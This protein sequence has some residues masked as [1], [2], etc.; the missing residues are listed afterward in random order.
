MQPVSNT[1]PRCGG[2]ISA[3]VSGGQCL[4][5]LLGL[6]L[7]RGEPGEDQAPALEVDDEF[8]GY[9]ILDEIGEGGC[10][11]VYRA[12]Q[13][14]TIRREVALKVIKLGLDTRVV[15]SRFEVERQA[16]ALMNHPHIAKVF[17]AGTTR[18]GRPFF[19]MEYVDGVGLTE[20]CDREG[21]PVRK[22]LELFLSVCDAVRHAHLKGVIHRDLK[23]SNILVAESGM[24]EPVPKVIDF[25][26]AKAVDGQQ[27]AEQTNHTAWDRFVGTPAYM[28]PEQTG[29]LGGDMDARS[30]I[31]AL[32]VLL[33]ELLTGC[34]P[35]DPKRLQSLP[36][37]EAVRVV[38]EEDPPSPVAR[39]SRLD[40][41]ELLP[42]AERRGCS[43][44]RL[45]GELRG[46]LDRIV[47][48]SIEKS[49]DRRYD[50][51]GDLTADILRH[52]RNEPVE[53]RGPDPWYRIGRFVRRNRLPLLAAA[54]V[55]G[56]LVA[57]TV[58]SSTLYFRERQVRQRLE[59][60]TY[61]ADMHAA[62]RAAELPS[63][64]LAGTRHLLNRWLD[65]RPDLRAWEWDY[66]Q[67]LC[68]H[69]RLS[70]P[71]DLE[72][73][74]ALAWSPDGK[75]LATG[76]DEGL[77]KTW[78]ADTGAAVSSHAGHD[79]AI[80]SLAW[81]PDGR[82]I[83]SSDGAS[84]IRLWKA[85]SDECQ[86]L[87]KETKGLFSLAWEPAGKRLAAGGTD[88]KVKIWHLE[89]P[90]QVTLLHAGRGVN[91]ICWSPDGR[92]LFACGNHGLVAAWDIETGT[93]LWKNEIAN[94][95][96][97]TIAC[98][99]DG[100]RLTTGGL[101]N[102]VHFHDPDT[103]ARIR[104]L[105]DNQ[106]VVTSVAWAPTGKFLASATRDD[107][108][109]VI[110]APSVDGR[111]IRTLRGHLA[112]VHCIAWNQDGQHL[113]SASADGTVRIWDA[114][115]GD[116]SVRLLQLPDQGKCLAWSPDSAR[117]A[118]GPRRTDAWI[119]DL[120]Q[121]FAPHMLDGG[122][123]PWTFAVAWAPDGTLLATGGD[124]GLRVWDAKAF[125]P[126]WKD[127]ETLTAISG[128]A[129]RPPDGRWIAGAGAPAQIVLWDA[130]KHQTIRKLDLPRGG[131]GPLKW[132]PDGRILAVVSGQDLFLF[133]D[134]LNRIA[135][136]SGHRESVKSL[137][138]SPDGRML[139]SS[140]SDSTARIW[141]T[142]SA[143]TLHVLNGHGS[144]ITGVDWSPDGTRLLT[145]GWDLTARLW[146]PFTGTEIATF[147]PPPGIVQMISAVAWS[148]DGQKIA[149]TDIEGRACV[150]DGS[151][152]RKSSAAQPASK[153]S[154]GQES[155]AA[156][157]ARSLR[158]YCEAVEPIASND[159]DALRR[160]AWVR[161]TSPY[162]EV[163]DGL[164][165]VETAQNA[166]ELTGGRSPGMLR[167]LAAA[168]A[169]AGDFP[170]AI[171]TLER[172]RSLATTTESHDAILADLQSYRAGKP[173][174]DDSW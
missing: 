165:A 168:Q 41:P 150:L 77:L 27:L 51:A 137:A 134:K 130:E 33:Y 170:K 149:I 104:S 109:I 115:G 15:I 155:R 58:V 48:K 43:P 102:A 32:G 49:P 154:S 124:K 95:Q 114:D 169:E 23:P 96:L 171:E 80:R 35:F 97:S 20:Y 100:R 21:L 61:F 68:H 75:L 72:E 164:K 12:F 4:R 39:L 120:R 67:G 90:D 8:P 82:W 91:G 152:G 147:H 18:R 105:F 126:V 22:R 37:A 73:V 66:L 151:P 172:A 84:S 29:I 148:P 166:N 157:V 81:S 153:T 125:A 26:I 118:V 60:R 167:I 14:K 98:S 6:G 133:D 65:R 145:G 116:P 24:G 1:C 52:L 42:I 117:L 55:L 76:G 123:T 85:G 71:A 46:D 57:G 17:D 112:S 146:D 122:Y 99:P 36:L 108:R 87:T 141:D 9:R 132:S 45:I 89:H 107:G 44:R 54:A 119:W 38:R 121:D 140:S 136:L 34:P 101:E 69:E 92:R 64:G 161:A 7:E 74:R 11:V 159:P 56:S 5:C 173:L 79:A 31:Y 158:L 59:T 127:E 93:Q 94:T 16:L 163:R 160:I 139:A 10:G 2:P 40:K 62:F 3:D 86:I 162:P 13:T 106:N 70:I 28:S 83:A 111:V 174:R 131:A 25:G 50:T 128:L 113:A 135:V 53:A 110:R 129:W 78:N 63:S 47:M 138:W 142:R 103:G 144:Q 30:D 19:V 156:E 143:Q 88:S